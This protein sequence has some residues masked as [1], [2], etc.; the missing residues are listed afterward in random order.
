[1]SVASCP[2]S[3][4]VCGDAP[5]NTKSAFESIRERCP[6][7]LSATVIASSSRSPCGSTTSVC[8]ETSIDGLHSI[9]STRYRDAHIDASSNAAGIDLSEL[10]PVPGQSLAIDEEGG[11]ATY[12]GRLA[13]RDV[14]LDARAVGV[15]PERRPRLRASELQA[16]R[17]V[18]QTLRREPI[19]AGQKRRVRLPEPPVCPRRAL[20]A[21]RRGRHR[22][23]VWDPENDARRA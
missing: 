13:T 2:S 7:R 4:S 9:W 5:M 21:R 23:E 8:R 11:R 6:D 15:F 17:D 18:E 16:A 12:P 14:R 10:T 22:D 19:A 3:H 20:R 1:M